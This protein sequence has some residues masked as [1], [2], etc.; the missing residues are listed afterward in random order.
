MPQ[1]PTFQFVSQRTARGIPAASGHT[2][3]S[4]SV[5]PGNPCDRATLEMLDVP[6]YDHVIVLAGEGHDDHHVTDAQTLITLLHLRDIADRNG[7]DL[8]VGSETLDLRN[9]IARQYVL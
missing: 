3:L 8:A 5:D 4:L 6:G 2:N 1:G 9:R 7:R